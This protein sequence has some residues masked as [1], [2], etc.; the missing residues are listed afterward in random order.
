MLGGSGARCFDL[1]RDALERALESLDG[2]VPRAPVVRTELDD[3]GGAIGA[4][5]LVPTMS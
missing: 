2:W 4:A 1:F 3:Y 5:H